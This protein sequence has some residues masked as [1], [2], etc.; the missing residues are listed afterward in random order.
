M[1]PQ[2]RFWNTLTIVTIETLG[3]RDTELPKLRTAIT[4][5][6]SLQPDECEKG[7]LVLCLSIREALF[8]NVQIGFRGKLKA[9]IRRKQYVLK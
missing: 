3:L 5:A 1:V 2:G 8:Q 9:R 4:L 7:K 6:S